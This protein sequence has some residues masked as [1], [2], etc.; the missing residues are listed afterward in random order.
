[1]A[2]ALPDGCE[3]GYVNT[4][5]DAISGRRPSDLGAPAFPGAQTELRWLDSELWPVRRPYPID[6][7]CPVCGAYTRCDFFGRQRCPR[8]HAFGQRAFWTGRASSCWLFLE[9]PSDGRTLI[10]ADAPLVWRD[11]GRR[12]IGAPPRAPTPAASP[13]TEGLP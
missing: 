1:M 3:S 9:D 7:P 11:D 4:G 2:A 10:Y 13:G 12:V 8:G 6:V 5:M